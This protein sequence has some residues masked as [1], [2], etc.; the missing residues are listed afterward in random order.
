M[1]R[2]QFETH[3]CSLS[4][5]RDSQ[6]SE[7]LCLIALGLLEMELSASVCQNIE[8]LLRKHLDGLRI[9]RSRG[10]GS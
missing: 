9:V 8:D 7:F 1:R 3:Q 4:K 2:S 10:S 6:K 5:V